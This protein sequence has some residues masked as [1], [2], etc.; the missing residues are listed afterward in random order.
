MRAPSWLRSKEGMLSI[1]RDTASI[2]EHATLSFPL[3]LNVSGG[4]IC[5]ATGFGQRQHLVDVRSVWRYQRLARSGRPS[6]WGSGRRASF[7]RRVRYCPTC[8]Q[9]AEQ[10][11]KQTD[12]GRRGVTHAC[13]LAAMLPVGLQS[14]RW[15]R[16]AFWLAV[17]QRYHSPNCLR[18]KNC[19]NR[20]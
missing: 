5:N 15:A 7:A 8:F 6:S 13:L 12:L 20:C 18:P 14:Q 16:A 4:G 17:P 9:S 11:P 19:R 1:R 10:R 3:E 2:S